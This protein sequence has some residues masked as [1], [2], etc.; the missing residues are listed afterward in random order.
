MIVLAVLA[1]L[2][3]GLGVYVKTTYTVQTVYVEGNMHYT[4]DE[5]K[6]I[7]MGGPFGDNSL[8]LSLKY[9]NKGISDVPFVDVIDVEVLSADTIKIHVIEKMLTGYI[10]MLDTYLYFDKD[11]YVVESSAVKTAGV[12]QIAGLEFDHVVVG[13]QLP[14]EDEE[15]FHSILN[16]T[17]LLNKYQLNSDKI[18]FASDGGVTIWFQDIKVTLGNDMFTLE[19][20]IMR[21]PE[22]LES[23]AGKSGVL[24]MTG[25]DERGTYT[26][27]PE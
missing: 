14:V 21:L 27:Q 25:Y 22:F 2:V 23:L 12:P 11:G 6:E 18:Y 8:F 26:F 7:V 1:V 5:I 13:R 24:Q 4:V 20:K 17:K 9:R 3:V 15:I 19:D 16:I 10:S